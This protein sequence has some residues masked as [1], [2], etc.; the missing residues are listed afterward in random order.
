MISVVAAPASYRKAAM[1]PPLSEGRDD[2][3]QRS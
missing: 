1:T 2:N 3:D